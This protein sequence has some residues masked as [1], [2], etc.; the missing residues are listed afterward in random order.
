MK[1]SFILAILLLTVL[2]NVAFAIITPPKVQ[3]DGIWYTQGQTAYIECSKTSVF[4]MIE[5][6]FTGSGVLGISIDPTPNFTVTDTPSPIS[7]TL[8]LDLTRQNGSIKVSFENVVD[9]GELLVFI[10][11]KPPTPT[12]TPDSN[13]CS[14]NSS[15]FTATSSYNFQSTKPMNLVWQTTGGVTVN[16]SNSYTQSPGLSSTVTIANSSSGSYSVKAIVPSCSNLESAAKTENMGVPFIINPNYW[17][18]DSYSNMWQFSQG[19]SGPGVTFSFYV[20]SGSA[21]LN[22]Q[23]QDCYITTSGGATI[24]VTG[25]NSCG[26]GTP[27]CFYLPPAS[28]MLQMVYPNPATNILSLEFNNSEP[29]KTI[30]FEVILYSK[31]SMKAIKRLSSEEIDALE[32]FNANQ[33]IEMNVGNLPRGTYFLHI[34]PD[35]KSKMPVQKTRIVLE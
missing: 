26:T 17:L 30:P 1:Y 13:I 20:S 2:S 5:A 7:K 18:F 12:I 10:Q 21:V 9:G 11:Q 31:K 33:K 16:G 19:V 8:N 3:I 29:S 23:S 27:Y 14:G 35:G 4:V 24:C 22:Q 32:S 6:Y 15:S 28:G 25:T 34:V